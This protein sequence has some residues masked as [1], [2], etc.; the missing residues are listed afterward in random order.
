SFFCARASDIDEL[1]VWRI[2]Q[3]FG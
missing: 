3:A 1:T 2:V